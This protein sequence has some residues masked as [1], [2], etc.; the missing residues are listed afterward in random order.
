[1]RTSLLPTSLGNVLYNEI[2]VDSVFVQ[3][4]F[5]QE[6]GAVRKLCNKSND[7]FLGL[8]ADKVTFLS[9]S[10]CHEL[11]YSFLLLYLP[12]LKADATEEIIEQLKSGARLR[13]CPDKVEE[14]RGEKYIP[15]QIMKR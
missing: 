4:Q 2:G 15:V 13:A 10:G 1:M 3:V 14:Y 7:T 11:D 6:I 9:D 8:F 12:I 5:S